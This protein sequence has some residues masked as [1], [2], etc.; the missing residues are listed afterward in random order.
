MNNQMLTSGISEKRYGMVI[1]IASIQEFVFASNSLK[2][3]IGASYIISKAIY[4]EVLL[5]TL[6]E[7]FAIPSETLTSLKQKLNEGCWE[8]LSNQN[9]HFEV[10]YIGGGNALLFF[11]TQN[12]AFRFI[13]KFSLRVFERFPS[14]RITYGLHRFESDNFADDQQKLFVSLAQNKN[15]DITTTV[16]PK[17]GITEEC[18][19]TGQAAEYPFYEDGRPIASIAKIKAE[20]ADCAQRQLT[21]DFEDILNTDYSF[22]N[23]IDQLGQTN[24][25]NFI[26][27]V[28]IDGNG[29]GNRFRK[30]ST[31]Q[32][33][34]DL[35]NAVAKA[36]RD[37]FKETLKDIIELINTDL[38]TNDSTVKLR[39]RGNSRILPIRPILIGGDDVT[40]VSLGKLGIFAACHFIRHLEEKTLPDVDRL[41]ACA[42]VSIVKTRYPFFRAYRI[43]EELTRRAKIKSR[44]N[45]KGSYLDFFISEA[46]F[47]GDLEAINTESGL[48]GLLHG[49]PYCVGCQCNPA[50]AFSNVEDIIQNLRSWPK[51]LVYEFR[52][53]L[54]DS[55]EEAKHFLDAAMKHQQLLKKTGS[56]LKLFPQ[57]TKDSE[58][59]RD[60]EQLW[61]DTKNGQK[62]TYIYDSIALMDFVVLNIFQKKE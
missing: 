29:M 9:D 61:I 45:S 55:E 18:A 20:L 14:L 32:Q 36:N 16:Y 21:D 54:L 52:Q 49:G 28:H 42:G 19:H 24:G 3:N 11:S 15:R 31:L 41:E 37:A 6:G 38:F 2:E 1:D 12:H 60:L 34:R 47:S 35:S 39:Q 56:P 57:S 13:E 10:G 23:E 17:L 53:T 48:E 7:L 4:G 30:C 44:N 50:D 46:G 25:N 58:N 5:E 8:D 51:N 26:A 27:V 22:T 62:Q 59:S 43:A 33:L 40:F